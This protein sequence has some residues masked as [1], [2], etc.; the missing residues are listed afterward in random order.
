MR[1]IMSGMT[2]TP[3]ISGFVSAEQTPLG[4]APTAVVRRTGRCG[5]SGRGPPLWDGADAQVGEGVEPVPGWDEGCQAAPDFEVDQRIGW[6]G[7]N[8]EMARDLA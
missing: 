5:R 8:S 7:G 4:C 2:T 1:P 3:A 6:L